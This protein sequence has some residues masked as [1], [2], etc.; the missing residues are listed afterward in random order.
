MARLWVDKLI[1]SAGFP[2]RQRLTPVSN[3]GP[4]AD[5][6]RQI[7]PCLG[8]GSIIVL[9]G[10]RGTGKTRMAVSVARCAYQR[11]GGVESDALACFR[12]DERSQRKHR[13]YRVIYTKAM[14]LFAEIRNTY[15]KDSPDPEKAAIARYSECSLLV[16]DETQERGNS[17]WEDRM[18]TLIL[19]NRY[20][21]MRDT[22][23]I[24]NLT[25]T[26]FLASVGPS[27]ASR[28]VETGLLIECNWDS[29][30]TR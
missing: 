5:A 17:D 25:P 29:F 28:I 9:C 19:D 3:T 8:T 14:M 23:L 12:N 11:F 22:M 4:W 2:V 30:R 21:S 27:I 26:A 13:P 18:L 6:Y 10:N 20:D 7:T 1:T 16:V 24:S 15:G